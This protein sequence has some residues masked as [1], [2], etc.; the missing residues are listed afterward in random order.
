MKKHTGY[1]TRSLH[2]P[3]PKKDAHNSLH[4]PVYEN[5]A[6]EFD[7]AEDIAD[8][9]QDRKKAHAYSR[10]TNPSVEYLEEKIKNI[11]GAHAVVAMSSGMAAITSVMMSLTQSGDNIISSPKL[12]AHSYGLF[13]ESMA[14]I[15]VETRFVNMLDKEKILSSIDDKTRLIFFETVTNPQLE[16]ADLEMIKNI[17]DQK[18]VLL[19]V[20]STITPF[21]VFNSKR[22]GVNIEVL[23]STKFI[24]GG[25]TSVGGIVID[26]GLTDWEKVPAMESFALKYKENA[27]VAK[28]RKEI[29]RTL[30]PTMSPQTAWMQSLGLDIMDLRVERCYHNCVSI[31]EYLKEQEWVKAVNYPGLTGSE[32]YSIAEKQF[33]GVPGTVLSF[34]LVSQ[35]ACFKFMNKLKII[36]RATN[37]NDNKTLI[38][39]P[40]T[41]IYADYP[42]ELKK[43][44]KLRDTMLRL[45]VGIED[46]T[47]L[48]EDI[49]ES[50]N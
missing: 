28:M 15:G 36:K 33:N 12:F 16:I 17:A 34:D 22:F 38:I 29:F 30:G 39:H 46:S 41:T 18:G 13:K 8:A 50:K 45:S 48:I 9:F 27:L 7:S 44:W 23:S 26:N 37:L 21:N 14:K 4:F 3:F 40:W 19:V 32:F 31:A 10:V 35:D 11:T 47:D 24:S 49:E 20:D 5:V 2:T 6:F 25:A 42:D 1:T 43:E